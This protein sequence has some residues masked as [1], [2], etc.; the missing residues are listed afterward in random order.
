MKSISLKFICL[1]FLSITTIFCS[2][3]AQ[4]NLT[5]IS[6]N[7]YQLVTNFIVNYNDLPTHFIKNEMELKNFYNT[8]KKRYS[9]SPPRI[10]VDYSKNN[11]ALINYKHISSYDLDSV[12]SHKTIY[13]LHLTKMNQNNYEKDSSNLLMMIVPKHITDV[14]IY[15]K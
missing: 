14:V 6:E 11:V 10:V 9:K 1:I 7:D 5:K 8:L 3:F 15:K 12:T 13:Y 2:C 4:K